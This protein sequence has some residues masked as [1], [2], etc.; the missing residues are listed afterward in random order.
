MFVHDGYV[1]N[2]LSK[3]SCKPEYH[4]TLPENKNINLKV[5]LC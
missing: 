4:L 3:S 1:K 2:T 5:P